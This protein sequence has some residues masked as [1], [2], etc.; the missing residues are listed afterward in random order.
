[1]ESHSTTAADPLSNPGAT[2]L[3][4]LLIGVEFRPDEANPNMD[5]VKSPMRPA[6]MSGTWVHVSMLSE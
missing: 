5:G 1:M 4:S 3:C 6:N 2:V